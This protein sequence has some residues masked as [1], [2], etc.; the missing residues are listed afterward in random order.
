MY[1]HEPIHEP[2][3]NVAISSHITHSRKQHLLTSDSLYDLS[4]FTRERL[5]ILEPKTASHYYDQSLPVIDQSLPGPEFHD[6]SFA[7]HDAEDLNM[8]I[9]VV[10]TPGAEAD[11]AE[12]Q[13]LCDQLTSCCARMHRGRLEGGLA[14]GSAFLANASK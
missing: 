9:E 14:Y 6:Q 11:A 1:L 12:V 10:F 3:G 7:S 2:F 8:C 13:R 4:T 5:V